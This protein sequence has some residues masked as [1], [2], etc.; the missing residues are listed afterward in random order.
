MPNI[1]NLL[2]LSKKLQPIIMLSHMRANTSLFGHILGNNPEINGYYEMH[3]GYY[4][5]KSLIR[6]KLKYLES[7]MFKPN[8]KYIFDKVLHNDHGINCNLFKSKGCH[9]IISL[10]PPEETIPSILNLYKKIDPSHEFATLEGAIEYY[11]SRLQMLE[12]YSDILKSN[13]IYLDA[14]DIKNRTNDTFKLLEQE[15]NLKT[16]LTSEYDIQKMTG[17]KFAGDHSAALKKGTIIHQKNSYPE[18]NIKRDDMDKLNT[19]FMNTRIEIAKN[20]KNNP[21]I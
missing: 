8:S 7:H 18:I 5:W 20:S 16:P 17:A 3:I 4:S 19:L 15:L 11:D 9:I 10:R 2:A 12:K 6:Q 14:N 21:I 13:F 1:L